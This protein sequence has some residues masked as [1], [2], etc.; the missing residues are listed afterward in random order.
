MHRE[1]MRS[2]FKHV[3]YFNMQQAR[4]SS[5]LYIQQKYIQK[6]PP[7][8]FH[9][10]GVLGSFIKFTGK[11][12]CQS[13][14]FTK[15]AGLMPDACSFI[16]KETLAQVF[17][18]EFCEISRNT[19]FTEHL[20]TTASCV[21]RTLSRTSDEAFVIVNYFRK[22]LQMFVKVLNRPLFSKS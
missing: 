20:R 1:K 16:K 6:Q 12:L 5:L 21:F 9:E 15:V 2:N 17:S 19:F 3:I 4:A 13:L 14:F 7:E 10:K 22:K 11:H 8:L 18:C